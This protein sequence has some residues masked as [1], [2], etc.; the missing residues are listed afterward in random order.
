[1]DIIFFIL[2]IFS[3]LFLV[4]FTPIYFLI[5]KLSKKSTRF[6]YKSRL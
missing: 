5:R 2:D 3:I 6:F 4:V 1:M